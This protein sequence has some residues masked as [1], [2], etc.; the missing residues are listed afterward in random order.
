MINVLKILQIQAKS[1]KGS[2]QQ[3]HIQLQLKCAEIKRI[4]LKSGIIRQGCSLSPVILVLCRAIKKSRKTEVIQI[5]KETFKV[6]SFAYDLIIY[7]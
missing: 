6:S 5:G 2:L 4:P 1:N 7:I 3:A